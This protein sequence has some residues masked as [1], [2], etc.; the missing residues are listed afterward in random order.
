MRHIAAV[1]LGQRRY[2]DVHAL[3]HDLHAERR[4]G[5]IGDVALFLEHDPV[6]TLGRG[7]HAANVLAPRT[8][9]DRAGIDLE[10]TGRGG[11]VTLHGPGQLVCYP[12]LDLNPDRRDV[13]RYVGDLTEVMRRTVADEGI[14]SGPVTGMVG[15]WVAPD[16]PGRWPGAASGPTIAKIGAIGVRMSRWVTMHGFALNVSIDLGLYRFIVPCGISAYP[17]TSIAQVT[18]RQPTVRETAE[19]ARHHLAA[20]FDAQV[21]ELA[22]QSSARLDPGILRTT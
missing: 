9:L 12:I 19:R 11:D 5:R 13:R 17:V 21:G 6:I 8:E 18:A 22:D 1:W 16:S 14:D 10:S 3:Q 2:A 15:L 4:A 7:S 20:V